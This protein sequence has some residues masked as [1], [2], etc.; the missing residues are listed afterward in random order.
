MILLTHINQILDIDGFFLQCIPLWSN[1]PPGG[2]PSG[3]N[4]G[5]GK[6]LENLRTVL[7]INPGAI[8]DKL[9]YLADFSL[10]I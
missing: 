6:R 4:A 3:E 8:S 7:I 10:N 1:L 5:A 9:A 2:E